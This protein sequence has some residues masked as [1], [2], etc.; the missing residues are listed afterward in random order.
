M[1]AALYFA[2]ERLARGP[3]GRVLRA[4]REDERAAASLGKSPRRY[5]LQAFALGGAIMGLG[6]AVQGHFIGFIAPDNYLSAMTFLVWAMLI[7]GGSGNNKG[8]IL[9]ALVVWGLWSASGAAISALVPAEAQ[10]RASALQITAIGVGLALALL[11][12]PRGLIGERV[13]VSRHLE[14]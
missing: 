2:L 3:W 8:A 4:I 14:E 1:V 7:L 10:A 5:R 13:L 6:G 11:L 9:G 12:R